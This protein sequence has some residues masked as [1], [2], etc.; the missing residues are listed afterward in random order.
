MSVAAAAASAMA[1]GE[2]GAGVFFTGSPERRRLPPPSLVAREAVLMKR[3]REVREW[4]ERLGKGVA[5]GPVK[6]S[7]SRPESGDDAER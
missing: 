1:V 5:G 2:M 3:L 6:V 4:R 7:G